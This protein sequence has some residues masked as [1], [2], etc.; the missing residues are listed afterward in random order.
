LFT[1]YYL[2]LLLFII[3]YL[4]FVIYYLLFIIY[5]LL[6]IILFGSQAVFISP[7][8]F[9]YLI[10]NFL[11]LPHKKFFV[12]GGVVDALQPVLILLEIFNSLTVLLENQVKDIPISSNNC[13]SAV[14]ISSIIGLASLY[15]I[16]NELFIVLKVFS[17]ISSYSD[18]ALFSFFFLYIFDFFYKFCLIS[19]IF[20]H[21]GHIFF[22]FLPLFLLSLLQ[23]QK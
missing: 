19:I 1:I 11:A 9:P 16:F 12:I 17:D 23:N 4:L 8:N 6:F 2:L 10:I 5:Y 21:N 20:L 3:Y 13:F 18:V 14:I 15:A 7:V 22:F